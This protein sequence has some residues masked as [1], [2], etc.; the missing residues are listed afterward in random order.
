MLRAS[1]THSVVC[2]LMHMCSSERKNIGKIA[3]YKQLE[4]RMDLHYPLGMLQI[5]SILYS[6]VSTSCLPAQEGYSTPLEITVF[7]PN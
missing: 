3:V 6:T 7:P 5:V 1:W 4:G 2:M